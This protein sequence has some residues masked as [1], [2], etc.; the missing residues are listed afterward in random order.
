MKVLIDQNIS[1]RIVPRIAH[2]FT[3][4]V[5]VRAL[6]WIDWNDYD[7]FMNARLRGF[8]AIITLDEDFNILLLEHGEPPKVI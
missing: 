6:D 3:E 2:V 7:I 1:Y 5:H 8:K 4:L